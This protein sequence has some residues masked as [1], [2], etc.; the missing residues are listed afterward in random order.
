MVCFADY[1]IIH[2]PGHTAGSLCLLYHPRGSI[3]SSTNDNNSA[4]VSA[5]ASSVEIEPVL[6][7]GD[8]IM[9]SEAKKR[10]D[11]YRNHNKA[12][13]WLQARSM[14]L[15]ADKSLSF[16]WILPA[17]GRARRFQ[18]DEERVQSITVAAEAMSSG[19]DDREGGL[20]IGYY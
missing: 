6:F 10:L 8:L 16:R 5:S 7:S 4:T 12:K 1:S 15:F 14:M 13:P 2:A 18:S 17:H 3:D 19:V 9:Y 11:G 20:S